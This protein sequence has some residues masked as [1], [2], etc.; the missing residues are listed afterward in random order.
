MQKKC[1]PN[2]TRSWAATGH[3]K[4]LEELLC[5]SHQTQSGQAIALPNRST[6]STLVA[7]RPRHQ[8]QQ[9][10]Q[11]ARAL[12]QTPSR[13]LVFPQF[14][15]PLQ[16]SHW[17]QAR[18]IWQI[19]DLSHWLGISDLQGPGPTAFSPPNL[20]LHFPSLLR[21]PVMQRQHAL[22]AEGD[23]TFSHFVFKLGSNSP[24]FSFVR[25]PVCCPCHFVSMF[26]AVP[27]GLLRTC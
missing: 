13:Q 8:Q 2:L 20:S 24:R 22:L 18:K 9:Q 11:T 1:L 10:T 14:Q 19:T 4:M 5:L 23:V 6:G 15:A 25:S 16:S 27:I 26:F 3:I 21:S 17:L 12:V 7:G